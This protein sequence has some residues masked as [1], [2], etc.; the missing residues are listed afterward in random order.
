[1]TRVRRAILSA[2]TAFSVL[3][4]LASVTFWIRSYTVGD[5]M[6][7]SRWTLDPTPRGPSGPHV[8]ESAV[9]FLSSAGTVAVET[10]TQDAPW[11]PTRQPLPPP[12]SKWHI[13]RPPP[14]LAVRDDGTDDVRAFLGAGYWVGAPH[15]IHRNRRVWAPWWMPTVAFALLPAVR[16]TLALRRRRRDPNLCPACGY[17]CRATPERCPECGATRAEGTGR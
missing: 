12:E 1:M 11:G 2:V 13:D 3:L 6:Y 14:P 4:F 9:W 10:R 7:R 17:D 5:R 16:L 8:H 15:P